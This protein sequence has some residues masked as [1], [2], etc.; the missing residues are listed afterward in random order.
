MNQ[1][2]KNTMLKSFFVMILAFFIAL[3]LQNKLE[4]NTT[5]WFYIIIPFYG[6][7]VN[8]L[9][10]TSGTSKS[11]SHNFSTQI[12]ALF[13]IKFFAYLIIILVFVLIEESKVARLVL[14]SFVFPVYLFN[15]IV[16]LQGILKYQKSISK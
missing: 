10:F 6:F 7:L 2:K 9:A 3:F 16:L 11:I 15:T 14:V 4:A 1:S 13:A 12:S 5:N 8:F